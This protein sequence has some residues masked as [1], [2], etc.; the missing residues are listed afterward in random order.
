[1]AFGTASEIFTNTML[2]I[3]QN[4]IALDWGTDD[5]Y[6]ALYGNGGTPAQDASSANTAYNAGA[7][8]TANEIY[9]GAEWPQ[10]GQ[11]LDTD[12][13]TIV[14][15]YNLKFDAADETSTGTSATLAAVYGCLVYDNSLTPKQ[16][17]SYHYFG[18]AQ[19]V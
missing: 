14:S 3:F 12:A 10:A 11:A 16:G 9:D 18:G 17:F 5:M 2:D 13:V 4:T 1:M 19:S 7:W 6:T 8:I 15:T